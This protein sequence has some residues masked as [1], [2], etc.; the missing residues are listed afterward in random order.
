MRTP[1]Y[2]EIQ[3]HIK[4]VMDAQGL[5][6]KGVSECADMQRTQLK[7]YVDGTLQVIDLDVL[8]RLCHTLSCDVGELLAYR[9]P[10][11][12]EGDYDGK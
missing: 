11:G 1:D 12:D 7:T 3:F 5:S 4:E 9:E 8:A 10:Q 6:I 2:G